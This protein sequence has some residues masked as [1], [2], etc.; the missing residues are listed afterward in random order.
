MATVRIINNLD[1]EDRKQRIMIVVL[2]AIGTLGI[3]YLVY[4]YV[5]IINHVALPEDT[6]EIDPIVMQWKQEGL[7]SSFDPKSALLVVE[8]TK[9]NERDKDT[10]IGIIV[11]LARYC[12]QKNNSS[13]WAVKVV[14]SSSRMTLGE[15]G[16]SGLSVQ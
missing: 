5:R 7:V 13:S 15:M 11:R 3:S 8:E 6:T 16:Q 12:A 4:D 10:K 9:W 1:K 14:G 2:F